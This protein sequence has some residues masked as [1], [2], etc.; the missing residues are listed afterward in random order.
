MRGTFSMRFRIIILVVVM[1]T[2]GAIILGCGGEQKTA[3]YNIAVIAK[4]TG[5]DFWQNVKRGVNAAAVEYNTNVTFIGPENEENWSAQNAMIV[6]AVARGADAIV[7]S[8]ID[9]ELTRDA[10]DAAAA[11]GVRIITIDSGVDSGNVSAFIGT[12]NTEAG[13]LA[14][15]AALELCGDTPA[16]LGLVN[17]SESTENVRERE[18]G[19]RAFAAENGMTVAA[20]AN[21][22]SNT[23]S[24]TAGAKKLLSEHPEIN[25]IIGFNEWMTLG[26][27][28]A[29]QDMGLSEEVAAVGFDSNVVS[30]G[31]LETGEMDALIVQNPFAI[32]YLGVKSAVELLG[33]KDIAAVDNTSIIVVTKENM[34]E[35]E[36]QRILFK[37]W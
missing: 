15:K 5:S 7:L 26:V 10:V 4:S 21:V 24:A 6:S 20:V 14:G 25:V 37:F 28:Y 19:L 23:E 1:I 22:E 30:V 35:P 34:F 11:A 8:A 12:D 33:G 27:G 3:D 9:Y 29:V 31:M 13:R 2:C 16:V 18:E 32:G 17:Y 36:V